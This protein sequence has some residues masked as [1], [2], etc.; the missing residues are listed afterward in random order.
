VEVHRTG[1]CGEGGGSSLH[2]GMHTGRM[3]QEGNRGRRG[4]RAIGAYHRGRAN[5]PD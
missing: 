2:R 3:G 5:G 4:S 1:S